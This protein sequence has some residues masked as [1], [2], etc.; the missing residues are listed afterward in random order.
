MRHLYT[1]WDPLLVGHLEEA[2]REQGIPCVV[3]NRYL[4]GGAGELPPTELWPQV[5]VDGTH[6]LRAR[7][8]LQALLPEPEPAP[9]W[10]C[11][12]CGE[13]LEGQFGACWR[14]GHAAP[15]QSPGEAS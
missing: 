13:S 12:G 1:G 4:S 8:I 5:W 7:E 9:P 11:P 3:R 2:L 6:Y 14:C 15:G 10:R